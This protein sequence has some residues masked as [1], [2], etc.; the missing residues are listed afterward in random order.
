MRGSVKVS[1]MEGVRGRGGGEV[2]L[3]YHSM[4]PCRLDIEQYQS[5]YYYLAACTDSHYLAACTDSH[6]LAACTDSHY[7]A[8]CTDSHYL[9]LNGQVYSSDTP[10]CRSPASTDIIIKA[11]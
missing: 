8:A 10:S 6:Y 3:S 2:I 9:Q 1:V 11:L 5:P 4:Q 7:L